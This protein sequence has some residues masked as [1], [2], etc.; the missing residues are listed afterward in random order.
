MRAAK[1]ILIL[2]TLAGILSCSPTGRSSAGSDSSNKPLSGNGGTYDGKPISYV[3]IRD[4]ATCADGGNVEAR[5]TV[6]PSA[7]A[8]VTRENCADVTARP[9]EIAKLNIMPHNLGNAIF[10]RQVFDKEIPALK[11]TDFLCRGSER[12]NFTEGSF[13]IVADTVIRRVPPSSATAQLKIG[14]YDKDQVAATTPV[15]TGDFAMNYYLSE[16]KKYNVFVTILK[17]N[18]KRYRVKVFVNTTTRAGFL[19]FALMDTYDPGL[20]A[21]ELRSVQDPPQQRI[22]IT[23]YARQK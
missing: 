12:Q 11:P 21:G 16:N 23:C 17:H 2:I 7:G 15:S 8:Q 1:S 10:E 6:S 22:A 13:Y 19:E 14:V 20:P 9:V 5:I 4:A 18:N 3:A